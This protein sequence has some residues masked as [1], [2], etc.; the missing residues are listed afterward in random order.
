MSDLHT[1]LDLGVVGS[2]VIG[3]V[4]PPQLR[5][6]VMRFFSSSVGRQYLTPLTCTINIYSNSS[7]LSFWKLRVVF[8]AQL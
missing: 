4:L 8:R 6:P 2:I 1:E 3:G 5:A 7:S